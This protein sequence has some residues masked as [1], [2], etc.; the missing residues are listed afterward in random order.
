MYLSLPVPPLLSRIKLVLA[1]QSPV[2]ITIVFCLHS[3]VRKIKFLTPCSLSTLS[4]QR[5]Y[6]RHQANSGYL[7]S[8]RPR[9]GFCPTVIQHHA[10][11][12]ASNGRSD[13][14]S[15]EKYR[16]LLVLAKRPTA[17]EGGELI[18]CVQWNS[19]HW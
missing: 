19:R 15:R 7:S 13:R 11:P 10:L 12:G 17:C 18:P 3:T 14:C 16:N 2:I 8:S 4:S 6:G 1:R 9:I 5:H